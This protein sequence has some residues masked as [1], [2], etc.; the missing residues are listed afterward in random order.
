[1]A[2]GVVRSGLCNVLTDEEHLDEV[3]QSKKVK[4]EVRK[5]LQSL[6]DDE[7][8]LERF[9]TFASN[10]MSALDRCISSCISTDTTFRTINVKKEK[11]W[12]TFHTVRLAEVDKLRQDLFAF[13][14]IS[15]L[16]PLIYQHVTGRLYE[17][18]IK[19]HFAISDEGDT[20][21]IDI[22]PLTTDEENIIR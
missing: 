19:T 20:C 9:D 11:I 10:L 15:R 21:S 5:F 14:G 12:G 1:M 18:L 13:N 22:P 2:T 4:D 16:C 7:A 8:S 6:N 3:D 17:D